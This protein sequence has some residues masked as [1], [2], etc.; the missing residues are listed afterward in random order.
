MESKLLLKAFRISPNGLLPGNEAIMAL[1]LNIDT[2]ILMGKISE[3]YI[4]HYVPV[5]NFFSF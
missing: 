3:N 2:L 1:L 4:E 5:R